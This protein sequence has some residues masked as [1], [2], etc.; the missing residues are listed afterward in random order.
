MFGIGFTQ[1]HD[2]RAKGHVHQWPFDLAGYSSNGLF[3]LTFLNA[4]GFS[5]QTQHI[6]G[7][8]NFLRF[9]LCLWLCFYSFMDCPFRG[10]LHGFWPCYTFPDLPDFSLKSVWKPPWPKTPA[11]CTL[12]I[13]ASHGQF[14][15][16]LSARTVTRPTWTMVQ[17]CLWG[18]AWW[19]KS[20]GKIVRHPCV[21]VSYN[22]SLLKEKIF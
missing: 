22:Y 13:R 18:W 12:V 4:C 6:P 15:G 3:G 7:N 8:A 9:S 11:F 10:C 1:W 21:I 16:L 20:W 5:H 14:Q 2:V 19:Y 17:Y